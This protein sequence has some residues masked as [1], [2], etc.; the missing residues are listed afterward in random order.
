MLSLAHFANSKPK[1]QIL[2]QALQLLISRTCSP[3]FPGILFTFSCQITAHPTSS[4]HRWNTGESEARW[5]WPRTHRTPRRS[6]GFFSQSISLAQTIGSKKISGHL[7]SRISDIYIYIYNMMVLI[8]KLY[9]QSG[10]CFPSYTTFWWDL[11]PH[12]SII[13]S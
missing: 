4:N 5:N 12:Q 2:C 8:S 3:K 6:G 7:A 9:G 10:S 11:T 1:S 13:N